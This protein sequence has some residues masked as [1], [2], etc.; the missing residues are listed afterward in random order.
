VETTDSA[1]AKGSLTEV[2]RVLTRAVRDGLRERF[3]ATLG[4]KT[5]DVNDLAAGRAYVHAYVRLIHY[6]EAVYDL[7]AP[8][9]PDHATAADK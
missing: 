5:F 9:A 6:A 3:A 4:G 1:L 2:D 8:G 7:T